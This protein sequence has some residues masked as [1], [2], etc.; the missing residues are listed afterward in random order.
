[1]KPLTIEIHGTGTHNRGAELMAIAIAERMRATFPDVRLVVSSNFGDAFSRAQHQFLTTWE[2]PGRG[3]ARLA[4][5]ALKFGPPGILSTLGLV[6]PQEIDVVLDASGFAFSDQ[7]G[8]APA[9]HL[10]E[11]MNGQARKRKPLILLPQA[12]GSFNIPE[13]ATVSRE[14][15]KRAALVCARDLQSYTM[16]KDVG[17][18]S[19]ILR[20]YPDFTVGIQPLQPQHLQLPDEFS[21]IVPNIR[22]MDKGLSATGYLDFLSRS[23]KLLQ[24][25]GM[26]PV[27]VLHDADGDRKV[28]DQVCAVGNQIPVIEH[29]DPRVLKFILSRATL[30][31]GS[32]FHAL[33]SSL[34]QGVPCIGAG[35][36]HKYLEL[37]ED[38]ACPELLIAD[39]TDTAA[40]ET[41]VDALSRL[42]SRL[43][44]E[45]KIKAAAARIK[46]SNEDMWQEVELLIRSSTHK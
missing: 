44:Y 45:K 36:S 14:L 26:N 3:R 10:L 20:R 9:L 30:V 38:F 21:V 33:V 46:E 1:M 27:F 6:P 23:I 2:F 12:I 34:S 39:I 31:L 25:Q 17:I 42:A 43:D 8:P 16:A 18:S 32:R 4:G 41:A 19:D 5:L 13:V 29:S 35:W 7:W 28:I 40:L 15:F 22:M 24:T 37:F 11:K